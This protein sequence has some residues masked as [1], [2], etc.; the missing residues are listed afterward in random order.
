MTRDRQLRRSLE[1]A[2][3][4]R[5]LDQALNTKHFAVLTGWSYSKARHLF[6]VEGFPA[7]EG[8]VFWSD[9]LRWRRARLNRTPS[10]TERPTNHVGL[11]TAEKSEWP[12]R[13]LR[14]LEGAE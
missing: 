10:Q 14:L 4:K 13:A 11:C 5:R 9:F 12:E 1:A 7:I 2:R 8:T 6:K 3:M